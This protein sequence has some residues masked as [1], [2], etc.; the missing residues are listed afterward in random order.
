MNAD[1]LGKHI[2]NYPSRCPNGVDIS[3][4]PELNVPD[5]APS[6]TFKVDVI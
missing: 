6:A 4:V 3:S 1:L 2:D 5:P